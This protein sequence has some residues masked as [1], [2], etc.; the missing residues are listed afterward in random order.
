MIPAVRCAGPT[1]RWLVVVAW[2][3]GCTLAAAGSAVGQTPSAPGTASPAAPAAPPSSYGAIA[4][5]VVDSLNGGT[6]A[7]AQIAVDG[8]NALAMTDSNGRFRID[9][10]PPGKYRIGI[11]HPLLDS[12]ALSIATVPLKIAADSTLEVVLG[13]PSA[14]SF[15]HLVCGNIQIDT[16]NGIGPSVIVGR[17]LDAETEAPQP[18]AKVTLSWVDIQVA[19]SIGLR[20]IQRVRDTTTGPG[21]EFRFCHLP[22]HLNGV[23][24]A[25][26]STADSGAVTRPYALMGHLVGAV[27]LHVPGAGPP[28]DQPVAA[29]NGT[30]APSAGSVL[31]GRVIGSDGSGPFAG[32]QVMVRGSN[33]TA[34]TNDSGQFTLRGLPTGSR[35]LEVHAL[36]WEPVTMPVDL[37]QR[38]PRQ[39][40]VPLEVK[41]AVLR[42]VVV[43]AT[44]NAGLHRV[45]FDSRKQMGIGRFLGPD[46][47]AKRNAFEFVDL[48]AG[49]P[50]VVRRPGP[51][52]EDYLAATRGM[53]SCVRYVVD[54][55]PYQ[56]MSPGDINTFVRADDIGAVEVYQPNE[57]PAQYA[58][59]APTMTAGS[60]TFGRMGTGA[61]RAGTMGANGGSGGGTSCMKIVIWTKSRLGL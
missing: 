43:T 17:V 24:R 31:T 6:L 45:G 36:G 38:E 27:V 12:L 16:M 46:D 53:A 2:T 4:G 55:S 21:G 48:M 41:T 20:R 19:A 50:G 40:T 5:L 10:V 39:V 52:G 37:A 25:F 3:L 35:T 57:S 8:L 13:T 61:R 54:G 18:Q 23:A 26:G 29:A 14:I 9:S 42:A 32:A 60:P 15:I 22:S 33:Q 1:T 49:M 34:V 51:S 30:A 7:G 47:I 58:Y 56:E 28:H 11:F 59:S 44:L